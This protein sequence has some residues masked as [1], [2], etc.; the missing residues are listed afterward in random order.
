MIHH[1]TANRQP[2][3]LTLQIVEMHKCSQNQRAHIIDNPLQPVRDLWSIISL[4][5][6]VYISGPFVTKPMQR[7]EMH[8]TAGLYL[9]KVDPRYFT[10]NATRLILA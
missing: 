2:N 6:L 3:L 8:N 5:H 4:H 1:M 9:R 7:K 10:R